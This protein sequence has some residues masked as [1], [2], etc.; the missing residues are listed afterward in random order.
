MNNYLKDRDL[1]WPVSPELMA[2]YKDGS[3]TTKFLNGTLF[4]Y[5]NDLLHRDGDK[6]AFIGSKGTLEW[7]KNG[8]RHRDDDR[9]AIIYA[10]GTLE[11][12]KD[13][14]LHR[15]GDKPA[16][17]HANGELEWFKNGQ[18]H[19]DDDKPAFIG[20][21]GTLVWY[22]N[23]LL[24]RTTGPAIIRPNN[25]LEYWINGV[26]ITSEVNSWLKTRKYKYQFTPDQ[27]VE[28]TLT[29]S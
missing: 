11:W 13:G 15:D 25:K 16:C 26:E 7:F 12:W 10:D 14:E 2:S 3:H 4:W 5:K 27:Q 17:I 1:W 23:G 6:P 21:K 19:R 22:K 29:F 9:P 18:P 8:L 24:H 28:F 20:S